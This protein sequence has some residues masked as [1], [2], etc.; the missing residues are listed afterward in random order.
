MFAAAGIPVVPTICVRAYEY[1]EDAAAVAKRLTDAF[2]FPFF[3]K[4]A[5]AGS[6]AL[7]CRPRE[8]TGKLSGAWMLLY[9]F[10]KKKNKKAVRA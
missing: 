5:N 4:P 3:V 6:S 8:R 10:P 2:K 9:A 7:R 1:R